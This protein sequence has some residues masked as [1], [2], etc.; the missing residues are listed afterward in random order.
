MGTWSTEVF[1]NDTACDWLYGLSEH[2]DLGFIDE[3]LDRVFD[4]EDY[5]DASV[6]MEALGAC[7]V[8]AQLLGRKPHEDN[9]DED[10]DA[11]IEKHKWIVS[12]ELLKKSQ[13]VLHLILGEQSELREL[14]E[15]SNL[16]NQW[17]E[18]VIRLKE[19]LSRPS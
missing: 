10:L 13:K 11:W 6:G 7:E 4:E 3:T 5:I 15:E 14:W 12:D 2:D 19:D 9:Q 18:S 16:Y 1:G 17:K 8:L